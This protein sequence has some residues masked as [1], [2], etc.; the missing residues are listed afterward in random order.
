M[1]DEAETS[2]VD[3]S[4]ATELSPRDILQGVAADETFHSQIIGCSLSASVAGDLETVDADQSSDETEMENV[5]ATTRTRSRRVAAEVL[6]DVTDISAKVRQMSEGSFSSSQNDDASRGE[7]IHALFVQLMVTV[8]YDGA[9]LK[10]I[11][12]THLPT[13]FGESLILFDS[14][15]FVLRV[16]CAV[17]RASRLR[18]WRLQLRRRR[19]RS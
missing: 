18:A 11:P 4:C 2:F 1:T 15:Q 10:S 7:S 9:M 3:A 6:D 12:A 5:D 19:T 17:R 13:C 8:R 14:A 16:S